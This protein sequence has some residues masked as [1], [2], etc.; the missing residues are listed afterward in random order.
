MQILIDELEVEIS[1]SNIG[2]KRC[3][4]CMF[5][6]VSPLMTVSGVFGR[7]CRVFKKKLK[8]AVFGNCFRCEECIEADQGKRQ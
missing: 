3:G 8:C 6:E 1:I 7:E 5:V 4:N 2:K